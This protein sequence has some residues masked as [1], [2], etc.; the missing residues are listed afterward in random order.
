MLYA[1]LKCI[2]GASRPQR[3]KIYRSARVSESLCCRQKWNH[4]HAMAPSVRRE[5]RQATWHTLLV[6]VK[7]PRPGK[8]RGY[9]RPPSGVEKG[10]SQDPLPQVW[11]APN[12][13]P[14]H[15]SHMHNSHATAL[16]GSCG[17]TVETPLGWGTHFHASDMQP[18][19]VKS[20]VAA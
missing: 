3:R 14:K 5:T 6:E 15:T 9:C 10:G 8:L 18:V 19:C 4:A 7:I 12:Q 11:W 16:R 17:R 1:S 2:W 20:A 13:P